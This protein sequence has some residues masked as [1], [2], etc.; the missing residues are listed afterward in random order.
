M[1]ASQGCFGISVNLSLNMKTNYFE[2]NFLAGYLGI[3]LT[4]QYQKNKTVNFKQ[5]TTLLL[6]LLLLGILGLL[7]DS[8]M[9][10]TSISISL[11]SN[12]MHVKSVRFPYRKVLVQNDHNRMF[13]TKVLTYFIITIFWS[14]LF[15]LLAG[16]IERNPG[17]SS[18]GTSSL[19]SSCC[20]SLDLSPFE[21]NFS[22]VHYNVQ[23][24]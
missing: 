10:C 23:A 2:S 7:N 16:D 15:I 6:P 11:Q 21:E 24:Y 12:T 22:V 14:L 3:A 17:P 5:C 19:S 9:W 1:V 20:S 18:S 13:I 4:L 8:T